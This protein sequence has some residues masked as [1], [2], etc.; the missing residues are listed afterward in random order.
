MQPLSVAIH[1]TN[2]PKVLFL[3]HTHRFLN[4]FAYKYAFGDTLTAQQLT[5]IN[6]SR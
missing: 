2:R 3:L 1:H 4:G 5:D 6:V